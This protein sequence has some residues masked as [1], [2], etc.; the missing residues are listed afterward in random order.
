MN[1]E[2]E[3]GDPRNPTEKGVVDLLVSLEQSILP[4]SA[5]RTESIMRTARWQFVVRG[6]FRLVD[7][8]VVAVAD[9]VALAARARSDQ[10][11]EDR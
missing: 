9:G 8:F 4:E 7:V 1:G 2:L 6:A 10:S 11:E 3:E 5:T